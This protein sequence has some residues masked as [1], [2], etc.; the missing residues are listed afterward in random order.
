M[1]KII[2]IFY[3]LFTFWYTSILLVFLCV[4]GGGR[5]RHFLFV[6]VGKRF[7]AIRSKEA[8]REAKSIPP[9][10]RVANGMRE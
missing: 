1:T 5:G 2:Y 7:L 10:Y 3:L 4:C 9:I 8:E 6:T